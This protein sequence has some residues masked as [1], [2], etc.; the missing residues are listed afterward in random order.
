MIPDAPDHP[1]RRAS[2]RGRWGRVLIF[3]RDW[4]SLIVAPPLLAFG[5]ALVLIGLQVKDQTDQGRIA[6]YRQCVG[7]PASIKK[8]R[9]W[10]EH[11]VTTP[12]EFASYLDNRPKDCRGVLAAG[13]PE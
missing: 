5:I 1:V 13:P 7:L 3:W 10:L 6:L 2:D 12:E 9:F 4:G 8:E 11:R